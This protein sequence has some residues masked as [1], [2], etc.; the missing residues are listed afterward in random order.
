MNTHTLEILALT[1]AAC[2]VA[3][4]IGMTWERINAFDREIEQQ[5][6]EARGLQSPDLK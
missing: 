5:E 6:R 3:F 4:L 2:A 1:V